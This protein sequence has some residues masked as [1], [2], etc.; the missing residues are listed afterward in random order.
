ML[1][2]GI[3]ILG[4]LPALSG[5]MTVHAIGHSHEHELAEDDWL[6][7]SQWLS[8]GHEH[9][10]DTPEHAHPAISASAKTAPAPR[11]DGLSHSGTAK[12]DAMRRPTLSA[13]AWLAPP[14]R[15]SPTAPL[16]QILCALLL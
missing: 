16:I 13:S 7:L 6:R 8:H 1:T 14:A 5:L 15:P 11:R 3:L 12:A 4:T 2:A 9:T 10:V